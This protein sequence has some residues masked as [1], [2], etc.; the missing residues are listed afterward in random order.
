MRRRRVALAGLMVAAVLTG[1][2][3][4]VEP[5]RPSAQPPPTPT[6][7]AV[8]SDGVVVA[9]PGSGSYRG[10]SSRGEPRW[11][12]RE[13]YRQGA[14]VVCA[15]RC[16]DAVLSAPA[17]DVPTWRRPMGH[18]ALGGAEGKRVLSVRGPSDAVLAEG[19]W[20]TLLRKGVRRTRIPIPGAAGLLWVED[21]ARS[22][23]LIA[24]D[25]PDV[26][27]ADIRWF[28]RDR[29]GWRPTGRTVPA[30]GVWGA[31]LADGGDLTVLTGPGA[32]MLVNGR[33][34]PLLTDLKVAAECAAGRDGAVVLDRWVDERGVR[35]TAVR[36]VGVDG[37]QT[38][39]RELA[40]EVTVA[41]E[42][43]GRRFVLVHDGTAEIVDARGRTTSRFGGV[44]AAA[45]ARKGELVTLDAGARP[46]R[47]E[48][49]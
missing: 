48:L 47:L 1:G 5:T 45:F 17:G 33:T 30:A 46:G 22:A 24:Y 43:D 29:H 13:A 36:G 7:V 28:R 15:A 18:A 37:R 19:G 44:V 49:G 27:G 21:P 11:T 26:A 38:W 14:E 6:I 3:A 2:C 31:C 16:P 42:P 12:D 35:H 8:S 34:V 25:D 4:A 9:D 23:A 39:A 41:A 10:Y 40:T 32:R 20:L